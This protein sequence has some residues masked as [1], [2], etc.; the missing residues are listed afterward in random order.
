MEYISIGSAR[1]RSVEL[2]NSVD[3]RY[4]LDSLYPYPYPMHRN[5]PHIIALATTTGS[6]L[7]YSHH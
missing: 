5:H 4:L 6:K 7:L 2:F 3:V 1:I